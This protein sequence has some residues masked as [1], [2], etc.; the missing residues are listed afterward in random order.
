M[1]INVARAIRKAHGEAV[2]AAPTQ[3]T[4]YR[5]TYGADEPFQV[6]AQHTVAETW[7]G[8]G[9]FAPYV[10][11]LEPGAP[12]TTRSGVITINAR[13]IGFVPNQADRV[14]V[15]GV[16]YNVDSVMD[17]QG[18]VLVIKLAGPGRDPTEAADVVAPRFTELTLT[19]LTETL[20]FAGTTNEAA[21]FRSRFRTPPLT[22][23]WGTGSWSVP[24]STTVASGVLAFDAGTW[25][26]QVQARDAAG[27]VSKWTAC[28]PYS[29]LL[30]GPPA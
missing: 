28:T 21:Q 16:V 22:G 7:T 24:Y 20:S 29:V 5:L 4:V 23:E 17:V 2:R 12:M 15:G 14:E 30:S 27:N 19:G 6:S 8:R 9:T 26:I 3:V 25:E 18:A 11:S 10:H 13:S 1:T